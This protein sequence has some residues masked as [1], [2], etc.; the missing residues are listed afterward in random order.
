LYAITGGKVVSSQGGGLVATPT[1][2]GGC[3][4]NVQWKD[5]GGYYHWYMHMRDDPL[6]NVGDEIEP[7]QLLGYVGNTG[8]SDGAHLHYSVNKAPGSSGNQAVNPLL[9][10]DTFE[11]SGDLE[12]DTDEEKIWAYLVN[13]GF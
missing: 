5:S 13:N 4:N 7:G 3:G 11:P 6:V 1:S 8:W 12:G 9:Y 10:W 2:N